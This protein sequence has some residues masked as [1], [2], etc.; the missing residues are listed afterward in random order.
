M[1]LK[2]GSIV[3]QNIM[4]VHTR[5]NKSGNSVSA[6]AGKHQETIQHSTEI[7]KSSDKKAVASVVTPLKKASSSSS[8]SCL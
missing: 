4:T 6:T 5:G 3:M 8:S 2:F 7:S 1:K